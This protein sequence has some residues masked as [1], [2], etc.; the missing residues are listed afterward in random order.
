MKNLKNQLENKIMF[1]MDISNM[2]IIKFYTM[3][4]IKTFI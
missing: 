4:N 1:N 3:K 2:I